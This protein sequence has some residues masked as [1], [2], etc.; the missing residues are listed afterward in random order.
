MADAHQ[1]G[2]TCRCGSGL[3]AARCCAL[4]WSRPPNAGVTAA[5]VEAARAALARHDERPLLALVERAPGC[6]PALGLLYERRMRQNRPAAGEALARRMVRLDANNPAAQIA[7][8]ALLFRRNALEEAEACARNA[9]RL[10]PAD[11]M[12]HGL[13]GMVMTEARQPQTGEHHYRRAQALMGRPNATFLANFAWCLKAQGRMDEARA[14]YARALELD[15]RSFGALYGWARL[16][17]ACGELAR[18]G[19]LLDR[20]EALAPGRPELGLQRAVLLRRQGEP[21]QALALLEGLATTDPGFRVDHLYERGRLLEALGRTAE[22]FEAFTAAKQAMRDLT[23]ESYQAAKAAE[24]AG[25][26][27]GFFTAERVAS[28]PRAG[29]RDDV[30]QPVFI[31]GFP[32]SGTT[33]IEQTLSTHPQISAGDELSL[34]AELVELAPRLLASPLPY[35][36][37]L[38]DLWLGDRAHGLDLLRDHYLARARQLG[39]VTEG[40]DW[41]TDKMPLNETHLGLISLVFPQAPLIHVLRHPLD[42]VLSM[43]G[44]PMSHGFHCGSD[45]VSIARHYVLIHE[46]VERHRRELPLRYLAVRYED[47]VADQEARVR[48]MLAFIG[49]PYDPRCLAFHENRRTA[50]TA[51]YAQV[52]EPLHARGRFRYRACLDQLAP[53]IPLLEPVIRK[54][55]YSIEGPAAAA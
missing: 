49:A 4:D 22:A 48:E 7:L 50:R 38:A 19:E 29:V 24:L 26:L 21:A 47:V 11:P 17:E 40:A 10:A 44:N 31:L 42:V 3:A 35:P 34:V 33:L 20:A 36:E 54:L 14:L 16:E 8:G 13:M 39:A 1:I 2:A 9:V 18:A 25:R 46:L 53:V 41:F 32:R 15:A 12:A 52:T 43:L 30:A 23:G 45:L 6:L 37:A 5:E 27:C 55:G 51:S 28:L